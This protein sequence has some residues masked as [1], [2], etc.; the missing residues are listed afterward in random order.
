[1]TTSEDWTYEGPDY[2]V[3]IFGESV[4][5]EACQSP[6]DDVVEAE[7]QPADMRTS[8]N[9]KWVKITRTFK[10]PVCGA[11]TTV[12]ESEPIESFETPR[13]EGEDF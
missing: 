10:C 5:H 12:E 3:G 4:Y 7:E 13:I 1:M 2:E 8:D 11:T 6:A 9:G